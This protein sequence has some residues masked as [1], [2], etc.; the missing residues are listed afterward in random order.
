M[1]ITIT[2]SNLWKWLVRSMSA[3]LFGVFI[4]SAGADVLMSQRTDDRVKYLAEHI[5]ERASKKNLVDIQV[6]DVS[7]PEA[8]EMLAK[9]IRVG[10]SYHSE[11]M[12]DKKVTLDMKGATVHEVLNKLLEGT[13]LEQVMPP[14]RDV[15][16]IRAKKDVRIEDLYQ[17]TVSGRVIDSATGEALPGVNVRLDGSD[18]GTVTDIDGI[19][20]LNLEDLEGQLVFSYIG[21]DR[22]TV[23]ISGRSEIDIELVQAVTGLN[24]VVVTGTAGDSRKRAIGNAVS[25]VNASDLLAR[26]PRSNVEDILQAQSPGMTLMPGSGTAGTSGNIRLR[27]AGSL[28]ASTQPIIYIDGIRLYT[29]SQGNFSPGGGGI[30]QSTSGLEMINPQD[31]ESIEVIKGP[32]ASTLYGAEAASG[33]IQII[34]K[35]GSR[36]EQTLRWNLR[37]EVGT[38]EWPEEW[39]PTN[40]SVCTQE[41]IDD[42]EGW[43]HCSGLSAG[44]LY[45]A[46]PL[47]NNPN[48]LRRGINHNQSLSVRGGGQQYSF[49]MSGSL[50]GEEGVFHNNFANRGNLRTNFNVFLLENL[51]VQ[52]N[53]SYAKNHIRLPLGDNHANSIIISSYLAQP[54]QLNAR[55]QQTG[56][57]TLNPEQ[58]NEYDNQTRTDRFTLG[59]VVTHNPFEWIQNR[60]RIGYD[61]SN[62]TAELFFPPNSPH[63]SIL[64]T[65]SKAYPRADEFTFDYDG[66]VTFNVN[67]N[68]ESNTSFGAQYLSSTRSRGSTTGEDFGSSVV[69]SV[70]AAAI[71]SAGESFLEQKSLGFYLQEQLGFNDKLFAT[72]AVRMDN[73][74]AFGT[75]INRVFYPKFSLSYVISDEDFFNVNNVDELRLRAAWGQ[76]GSS[77]GPFDAIR[78]YATTSTTLPDGSSASALSYRTLG[79]PDLKPE[80]A[81]EVEFGFDLS[82]LENRFELEATYY[83]SRTEDALMVINTPP[84]LG[85]AGSTALVSAP[86]VNTPGAQLQNMGTITNQGFELMAHITPLLTSDFTIQNTISLTTNKNELVSFGMDRE[87]MRFGVYHLVHRFEE[88]KPLAAYWSD[89][90]QQDGNGNY[91]LDENGAPVLEEEQ[92]YKGPSVPTREI[93]LS[94]TLTLFQ[95]LQIYALFDYKGGHYLFN[96]KDWRRDRAGVS[97]ETLNPDANPTE[98]AARQY[99]GQTDIHIQPADFIKFRDLSLTYNLPVELLSNI[100]INGASFTV[101]A[102]N[103]AV[104]TKYGGADPEVNFHGGDAA[105]DRNDSW[106]LPMSRRYLASFNLQF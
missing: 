74:S 68:I 89:R 24:E 106:T 29:G 57:F 49:Y 104:W 63:G 85:F 67:E 53:L 86:S 22:Q 36:G 83:N 52:V 99:A 10:L 17:A 103:L 54:A 8:L 20:S 23:S 47:S 6:T 41:R 13:N 79:N 72:A 11:A 7:L 34:T 2:N 70:S 33:V 25:S 50:S 58:F 15:I 45:G 32:A 77:P 97:W 61:L 56:Y 46:V 16:V 84:S 76:A 40:Y 95:N 55:T 78:S 48:A 35:R 18:T 94:T 91:I 4:F 31:I 27:G 60:F 101:T 28:G 80:R 1:E 65:I 93:G 14:S 105:F 71:T 90:V 62:G 5:T 73:N 66:T 44:N 30:G 69:R 92:V 81:T 12:T 51:D 100:G 26:T 21:Y 88:G 38:V 9:E 42:P 96:V 37:S 102:Q 64:G 98:V 19:Y 43:P 75:E 3:L 82:M 87:S 39:R 59:G